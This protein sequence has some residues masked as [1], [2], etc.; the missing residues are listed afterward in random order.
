MKVLQ[1]NILLLI[2][3]VISIIYFI[4][5]SKSS[6]LE[7]NQLTEKINNLEQTIVSLKQKNSELQEMLKRSTDPE[8][9][10]SLLKKH[11][12]KKK[13]ES[14][15]I[16]KLPDTSSNEIIDHQDFSLSIKLWIVIP[17]FLF[18]TIL[19]YFIYYKKK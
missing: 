13:S 11:N 18:I 6:V 15:V 16:L 19:L 2:L 9:H 12:I 8:F 3:T 17:S 7:Y 5:L 10:D 4:F 1:T 14:L